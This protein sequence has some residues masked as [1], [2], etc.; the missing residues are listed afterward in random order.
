MATT[1]SGLIARSAR[2]NKEKEGI[3]ADKRIAEK[4]FYR[5]AEGNLVDA[6]DPKAAF[7]VAGKGTE[8]PADVVEKYGI[9]AEAE[10]AA[11]EGDGEAASTAKATAPKA[12]KSASP[13]KNKG[14]K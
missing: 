9:P 10:A 11:P 4:D 14:A 3:M 2:R 5:D 1:T 13:A 7:L 8:I 6:T 12:N